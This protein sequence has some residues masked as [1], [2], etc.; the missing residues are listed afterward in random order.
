MDLATGTEAPGWPVR[1]VF[2]RTQEHVYG[3]LNLN[4]ANGQLYVTVASHCDFAPYHGKTVQIDVATHSIVKKW[5]PA[6]RVVSGGGIWGPGGAALDPATNHVFVA[7][8]NALTNPEY[9]RYSEQ[10]V[11]LSADL[12][13]QGANYPGLQGYDVDFG[14]T[15]ILYQAPGCPPQ[16]AAKNKSGVLVVYTRGHVGDGYTASSTTATAWGINCSPSTRPPAPPSG[17]TGPRSPVR[18]SRRRWWSTASCTRPHG[19]TSCTRSARDGLTETLIPSLTGGRNFLR[20]LPG[21]AGD[22]LLASSH[23]CSSA[24]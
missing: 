16:V 23:P 5:Y 14:A 4:A 9:Y 18:S 11:E 1:H 2:D 13:V 12:H 6:G 3:G 17:T 19:T 22:P 21:I 20:L 15:P 8:G 7:T 10:V 24:H